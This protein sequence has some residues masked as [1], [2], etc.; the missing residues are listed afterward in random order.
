M[1]MEPSPRFLHC[2]DCMLYLPLSY[3]HHNMF[4]TYHLCYAY[5]FLMGKGRKLSTP[6]TLL[7]PMPAYLHKENKVLLFLLLYDT[8]SHPTYIS[9]LSSPLHRAILIH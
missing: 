4:T 7:L 1:H 6:L 5:L 3:M 8:L 2:A 9:A